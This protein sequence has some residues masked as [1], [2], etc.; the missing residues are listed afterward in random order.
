MRTIHATEH[1]SAQEAR[2]LVGTLLSTDSYDVLSSGEDAD[3]Y[4]P[5]ASHPP[6]HVGAAKNSS[7][8]TSRR[9]SHTSAWANRS[10]ARRLGAV[11]TTVPT[12]AYRTAATGTTPSP[13]GRKHPSQRAQ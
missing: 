4:K 12:S 13:P 9:A 10:A 11:T 3:V 1:L 2:S 7:R 5:I 6:R 8:A